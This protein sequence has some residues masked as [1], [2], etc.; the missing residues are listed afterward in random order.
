MNLDPIIK[1]T[2]EHLVIKYFLSV[3]MTYN[4]KHTTCGLKWD[5]KRYSCFSVVHFFSC[6]HSMTFDLI[7]GL[8]MQIQTWHPPLYCFVQML[9]II[10][11]VV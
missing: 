4:Y 6:L 9:N 3:F 11:K 5:I 1:S 8:H 10:L 2:D 7:Y